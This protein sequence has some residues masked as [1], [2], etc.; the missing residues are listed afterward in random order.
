MPPSSRE[1]LA[2]LPESSRTPDADIPRDITWLEPWFRVEHR[3]FF[4]VV[5]AREIREGHTLYGLPLVVVG[6]RVEL[7]DVLVRVDHPSGML[8][9]VHLT[10]D[11][12]RNGNP[13]L[14]ATR[15]FADWEQWQRECLLPDYARAGSSKPGGFLHRSWAPRMRWYYYGFQSLLFGLM[16]WMQARGPTSQL[17]L[18]RRID[19]GVILLGVLALFYFVSM[20]RAFFFSQRVQFSLR[21]LLVVTAAVAIL[22]C[23]SHYFPV[24][25]VLFVVWLV[26]MCVVPFRLAMPMVAPERRAKGYDRA[27]GKGTT[28]SAEP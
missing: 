27:G 28:K 17:P 12:G 3:R 15:L 11:G 23:I 6:F 13:A 7:E 21:S 8:A 14:P 25:W 5:L 19:V 9:V 10:W 2:D 20:V 24:F 22:C 4:E 16:A 26:G 18:I 1:H